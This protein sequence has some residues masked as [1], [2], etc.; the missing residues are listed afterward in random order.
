MTRALIRNRTAPLALFLALAAG[1][2]F[3]QTTAPTPATDPSKKHVT[4]AEVKYQAGGSPLADADMYQNVNPK[5]PP[6]TKAEFDKGRKV[7]F[8]RCAGCHGVLRKGATGKALT[9]DKTLASG[10]EYLKVFIKYGSPAGM[11]NW[12]TS[13]EL[14]DDEVDLMARYIQQEPPTPPEYGMPE[15]KAT[16]KVLIAPDKR[17]TKKLN[18]YNIEN[19]FST[20]LRDTGEVALID[21]DTKKIISIIKT[22]YAVHIS[23]LSASGRYLFVIGRDAKINLIDLWMEKPDNVAEI[24]IGLE[25]RSVDTSKF[26]GYEDKYAIAGAYWPPQFVIMNGD[27][28]EPLKIVATRG[29]TV[30]T[31]EYHPEPRV[32]S[33]AASHF[34]PEFL[35]SVKETG[36]VMAVDYSD[37]N[38]LKTTEIPAARFLHD[39][40]WDSTKRYFL[41]A[42]NQSNM[43]AVIDAKTDKKVALVE[44]GKIPHPGRGANFIHPKFG[45]VWATGHLGDET[46][47]LIAT[48]PIKHKQHAWKMVAQLKGQGGGSLFLKTHPKSKNLWVDTPLNPDPKISQSIAVY[49]INNLDKGFKVLPIA[50]WAGL[51]DGAKRVVQP[52]YNKAGDE[53]WFSVWS[54]KN[55]QSAIVVVDDKTLKLKAVIKDPRLVTPTG[56]FNVYNTQHDVY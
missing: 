7:Y 41:V 31:Q 42:A 26:K 43:I 37:L 24:R 22:G 9:T 48:D 32:A 20:T 44:V 8:E 56:H 36:K 4:P 12:G 51:T 23:R 16:W 25:A 14:T 15:M 10:T 28:L 35:V 21:G 45:P 54:A 29:M 18:K 2:A 6:M 55:Q 17:P 52:E 46:V 5:A 34:K 47:A 30:D 53:V 3:A 27:T 33:I 50:E 11:P 13:G 40:G 38:N 49:D 39:G 19:I 1:A